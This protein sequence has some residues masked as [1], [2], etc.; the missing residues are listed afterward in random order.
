MPKHEIVQSFEKENL[1]SFWEKIRF[2]FFF[3]RLRRAKLEQLWEANMDMLFVHNNFFAEL[4]YIDDEDRKQ[5]E[6]LHKKP[7]AQQEKLQIA[8][9]EERITKAKAIKDTYRRTRELAESLVMY[10]A[11]MDMWKKD[12]PKPEPVVPKVEED[13]NAADDNGDK[14]EAMH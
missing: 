13:D 1:N 3:N 7:Y 14:G 8:L 10:L 11:M 2:Y 12:Y 9:L 4:N 5:L 6:E